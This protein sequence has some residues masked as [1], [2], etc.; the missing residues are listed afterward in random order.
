MSLPALFAAAGVGAE[1]PADAVITTEL[2]LKYADYFQRERQQVERLRRMGE[3]ALPRELP[4][5][6][7]RSLSTEARQ[8]LAAAR[9][10]TL[11]QASRVPGVSAAD[12]QNLVLEVER[13]RR[14]GSTAGTR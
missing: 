11:A 10:D 4:W 7:L 2:E 6:E 13:R 9:P 1:L 5:P 3:F 14:G 12:L 8:K